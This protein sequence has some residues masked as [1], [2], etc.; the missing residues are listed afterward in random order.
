MQKNELQDKL[1]TGK[2]GNMYTKRFLKSKYVKIVSEGD[3]LARIRS[4]CFLTY[5][6]PFQTI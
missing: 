5:I 6:I 1:I 4:L 3:F 2:L